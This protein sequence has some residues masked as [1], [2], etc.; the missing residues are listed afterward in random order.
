MST[1]PR[2]G[3]AVAHPNLALVKYWGKRDRELN[4][5]A[6]GSISITLGAFTTR[7]RVSFVGEQ[8]PDRITLNGEQADG[9][10]AARVGRFLDLVRSEAGIDSA[11]TVLSQNDYP[12]AAG[13]ASSSAAFSALAVA[14]CRAAQLDPTPG[15]LSLLSRRGSGSAAR[16]VFGGFVE[17]RTGTRTDGTDAIAEPLAAADHWDLRIVVA[18]TSKQRKPVGSSEGMDL[19][20]KTSPY[21]KAWVETSESD[22]DRARAAVAGRDLEGLGEVV[23]HSA[24]KM[25]ACAMAARPGL[26]YWNGG[27]V[28]AMQLVRRARSEGLPAYFTVDAGPQ[29]KVL[30]LPEHSDDLGA[31][32]EELP[33]V[34]QV[35]VSPVGGPARSLP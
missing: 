23:E 19:T 10:T 29:V 34:V 32:L 24:L 31:R 21:Y 30:C 33:G 16:S 1:S 13:L 3:E 20:A 7:T 26:I 27:T 8:G 35:L 5:P 18:L 9:G 22:L 15:E 11:A 28:E 2:I 14:A 17:M 12:T 4:L 6:T 25:H